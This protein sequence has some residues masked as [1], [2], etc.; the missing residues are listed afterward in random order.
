MTNLYAYRPDT[1][2]LERARTA[3]Y[4]SSPDINERR[5]QQEARPKQVSDNGRYGILG[6]WT[7]SVPV[8]AVHTQTYSDRL[9][10][11]GAVDESA[12]AI[13]GRICAALS[14]RCRRVHHIDIAEIDTIVACEPPG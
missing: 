12:A 14:A 4:Q 7:E 9:H 3:S 5:I 6:Q 8:R 11:G 10:C 13:H 2:K 1:R